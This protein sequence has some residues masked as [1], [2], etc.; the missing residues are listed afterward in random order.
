MLIF[1]T[2]QSQKIILGRIVIFI[3]N[4]TY[5]DPALVFKDSNPVQTQFGI[6]QN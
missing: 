6:D 3:F 1:Q 4:N 5:F 2:K